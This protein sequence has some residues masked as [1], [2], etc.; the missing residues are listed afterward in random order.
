MYINLELVG[1]GLGYHTSYDGRTRST[2]LP[3]IVI[4]TDYISTMAPL[5]CNSTVGGEAA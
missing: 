5:E 4:L 1:V 3:T 2:F